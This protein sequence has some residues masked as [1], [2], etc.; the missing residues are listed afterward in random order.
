MALGFYR[1]ILLGAHP[2]LYPRAFAILLSR[3]PR[4]AGEPLG[5]GDFGEQRNEFPACN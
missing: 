4:E 5:C 2:G 1:Y 3:A